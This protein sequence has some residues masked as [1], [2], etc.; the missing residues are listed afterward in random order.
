[1]IIGSGPPA[2][3]N[4]TTAACA[5]AWGQRQAVF[6]HCPYH[7]GQQGCLFCSQL[8]SELVLFL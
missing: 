5:G 3:A 1:M 6:P 7:P 4:E 8:L 2:D